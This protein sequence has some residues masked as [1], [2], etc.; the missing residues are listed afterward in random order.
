MF[1][2]PTPQPALKTAITIL[3]TAF[4]VYAVVSAKM[5]RQLPTRFVR[6]DRAGGTRPNLVTDDARIIIDCFADSPETV[7]S[8][9]G[10]VDAAMHNAIGTVVGSVFVRNWTGVTGPTGNYP[11]PDYLSFE[12]WQMTG[13]LMLST[14][15]PS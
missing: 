7:E 5:P 1:V 9:C 10:T 14:T 3:S 6:V 11:H 15:T 8:M 12:R 2:H 4:G 13:S